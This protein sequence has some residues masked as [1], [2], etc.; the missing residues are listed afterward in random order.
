MSEGYL[1]RSV[2]NSLS[3]SRSEKVSNVGRPPNVD[4]PRVSNAL[5]KCNSG[6]MKFDS[7]PGSS[8][9]LSLSECK[10]GRG[11]RSK[12]STLELEIGDLTRRLRGSQKSKS[13]SEATDCG[14]GDG[15][16]E[17]EGQDV[18]ERRSDAWLAVTEG[19]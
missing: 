13:V 11:G 9:W 14:I 18:V 2:T 6:L 17:R 7:N 5:E 16:G 3:E 19:G 12:C 15:E 1:A 10:V 8:L 4:A